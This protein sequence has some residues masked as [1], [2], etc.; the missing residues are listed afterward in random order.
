[1]SDIFWKFISEGKYCFN[2][3]IILL[4]E[5]C[6]LCYGS[7]IMY[8]LLIN[9]VVYWDLGLLFVSKII[10]ECWSCNMKYGIGFY[11]DESGKYLYEEF[12]SYIEVSN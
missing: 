10:F 2:K 7:L 4:V 12:Y 6:F 3:F 1:M 5:L 11:I 8:Y 9:V